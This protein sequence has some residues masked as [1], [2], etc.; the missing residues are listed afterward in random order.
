M[1]SFEIWVCFEWWVFVLD[2]L[3]LRLWLALAVDLV[4]LGGEIV[5]VVR[6]SGGDRDVQ[7]REE[8]VVIEELYGD[9]IES[10]GR[11]QSGEA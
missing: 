10:I 4:G 9:G 8:E 6:C 3:R 11:E 7:G 5:I 1:K 2:A